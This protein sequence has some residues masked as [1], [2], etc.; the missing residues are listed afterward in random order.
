MRSSH[1]TDVRPPLPDF[2]RRLESALHQQSDIDE[3]QRLEWLDTLP[4]RGIP[5]DGHAAV[6]AKFPWG[7]DHVTWDFRMLHGFHAS[8]LLDPVLCCDRL[9]LVYLAHIVGKREPGTWEGVVADFLVA[10][11][12]PITGVAEEKW[13]AIHTMSWHVT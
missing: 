5:G 6:R 13:T 10:H 11:R 4:V 1:K 9:D 8:A 12:L 3:A 7:G 2:C